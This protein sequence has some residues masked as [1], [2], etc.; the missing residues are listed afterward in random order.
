MWSIP[1][2][3][4]R[5][6]IDCVADNAEFVLQ[7]IAVTIGDALSLLA[8]ALVDFFLG[9]TVDLLHD[10]L[11]LIQFFTKVGELA[12]VAGVLLNCGCSYLN[13]VRSI[14]MQSLILP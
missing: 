7:T 5:T 4:L 10:R 14:I 9:N 13:F 11:D 1:G 8:D 2:V 12:S 6:T 3:L